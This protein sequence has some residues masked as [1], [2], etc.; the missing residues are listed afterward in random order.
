MHTMS[1]GKL[2]TSERDSVMRWIFLLTLS[3]L[4]STFCACVDGFE[5]LS[6]AFRYPIQLLTFY[7]FFSFKLLNNFENAYRNPLQNFILL[8][9]SMSCSANLSLAAGIMRKN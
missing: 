8:D 6:R 4:I 9:R 2:A 7:L 1:L 3:I 5:G